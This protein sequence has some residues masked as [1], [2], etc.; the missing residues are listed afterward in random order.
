M[1]GIGSRSQRRRL[2]ALLAAHAVVAAVVGAAAVLAPNVWEW[3]VLHHAGEA[4]AVRSTANDD[5]KV[6][7]LVIRMYGALIAAQAYIVASA[8][9]H[10]HAESR[11]ALVRAYTA[12]F[13][14]TTLALLR[15]QLTGAGLSGAAWLVIA[16][17][18]AL[19]G[20][21]G[22]FAFV[23]PIAV[24]KSPLGGE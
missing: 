10:P 22:W 13:A 23:E 8:R 20:G 11:R 17:F 2:D 3:F 18:A 12:A 1:D 24:F 9:A 6:T 4:L 5:Q 19:T 15:A 21:Y 16:L 7:H 14:V